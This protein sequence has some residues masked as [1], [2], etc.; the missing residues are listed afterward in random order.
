MAVQE[1]TVL[2]LWVL[3]LTTMQV[4]AFTPAPPFSSS[5][6]IHPEGWS[7]SELH[8]RV[9]LSPSSSPFAFSTLLFSHQFSSLLPFVVQPVSPVWLG[10]TMLGQGH[11]PGNRRFL[12]LRVDLWST[13]YFICLWIWLPWFSYC[14]TTERTDISCLVPISKGTF[15]CCC[16]H[17]V[18]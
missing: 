6:Y 18:F 11:T 17:F 13:G 9:E 12:C 15:K 8:R 3:V 14:Q 2:G 7:S 5:G 10:I 4:R 1:A 16:N